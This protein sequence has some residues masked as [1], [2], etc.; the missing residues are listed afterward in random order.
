MGSQLKLTTHLTFPWTVLINA[1]FFSLFNTSALFHSLKCP[2]LGNK[3]HGRSVKPNIIVKLSHQ[4]SGLGEKV[5][6]IVRATWCEKLGNLRQKH[7]LRADGSK[8]FHY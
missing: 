4:T 8:S 5:E 3:L 2:C 7:R 6:T 1:S